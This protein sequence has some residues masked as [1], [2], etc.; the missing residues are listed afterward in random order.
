AQKMEAIGRL[1]AGIAHDYN[2]LLTSI[3]GFCDMARDD[4]ERDHPVQRY[5]AQI[6]NAAWRTVSL[7]RQILA[8]ASR[9]MAVPQP[10]ILNEVISGTLKLL[11]RLM[12]ENI[13]LEWI[14]ASELWPVMIDPAQ[15][16]QILAN[17]CVNARDAITGHGTV[18]IETANVVL[19]DTYCASHAG[20]KPGEYTMLAV[21]DTGCGMPPEIVSRIFEPF[22]T[23]KKPGEG[24][25]LG[26]STVYGIVKQNNG[27]I[28]VYSEPGQ[29][30]TFR[31]YLPRCSGEVKHV[32]HEITPQTVPG[33]TETILYVEDD[34][35]V[36]SATT[37]FLERLGYSVL[38]NELPQDA[39]A[40]AKQYHGSIE[41]LIT[42][43]VLRGMNGREL[44]TRL[45]QDRPGMKVLY[46]SGYTENVISHH[47][48]LEQGVAFLSK[49]FR[50]EDLARKIR[51]ILD[52]A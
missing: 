35:N 46:V 47:G 24:T 15:V 26:L 29:G 19:D 32:T 18:T 23:T 38:P 13:R 1:A 30:T 2:N 33:G 10:L 51:Q 40:M 5:L 36:R 28:N 7:N 43:V 14:P 3:I 4:L 41:M 34:P 25:G 21:S 50:R 45:L 39:L 44:A 12:G 6:S 11:R 16:D 9:Q 49:P 22:F 37:I 42:D 48:L 31:I 8:F 20:F 52:G 17:L 27:Y